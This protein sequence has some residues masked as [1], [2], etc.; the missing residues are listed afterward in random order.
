MTR[1]HDGDNENEHRQTAHQKNSPSFAQLKNTWS[2][3]D[4]LKELQEKAREGKL[5][6]DLF[7]M[8]GKLE[9][10]E[11]GT[12]ASAVA[13]KKAKRASRPRRRRENV[14]PKMKTVPRTKT[15]SS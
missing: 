15:A 11:T 13:A 6:T 10:M 4:C 3:P 12:G 7:Q 1:G 14:S 5:E 8:W 2:V 9:D